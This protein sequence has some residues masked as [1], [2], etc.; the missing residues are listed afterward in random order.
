MCRVR[1]DERRENWRQLADAAVGGLLTTA[2]AMGLTFS[3]QAGQ[4]SKSIDELHLN[5]DA[6]FSLPEL[7]LRC[8]GLQLALMDLKVAIGDN[9]ASNRRERAFRLVPIAD[10]IGFG[11]FDRLHSISREKAGSLTRGFAAQ[12][13]FRVRSLRALTGDNAALPEIVVDD[14]DACGN[15]IELSRHIFELAENY[16][17]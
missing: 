1:C 14:I 11:E 9:T 5:I 12:Y 4:F 2:F 3:A 15:L 10:L 17:R 7:L 16:P 13:E 8:G 6:G